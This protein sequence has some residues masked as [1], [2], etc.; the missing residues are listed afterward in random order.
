MTNSADYLCA[1]ISELLYEH[2]QL[3][4][5]G[6]GAFLLQ[7][8]PAV[9]D[10]LQG[11]LL[12][13]SLDVSFNTNL[14]MDDGLL[15]E[16]LRLRSGWS[17][18]AASDAINGFVA[19]IQAQLSRGELVYLP[20]IGRLHINHENRIVFKA[21]NYNYNKD[22]FGLP[23][24]QA[25]TVSRP[26]A[27]SPAAAAAAAAAVGTTRPSAPARS[28]GLRLWY[29][30]FGVFAVLTA[31][32]IAASVYA[33]RLAAER[34]AMEAAAES[35]LAEAPAPS[36]A[37]I[38]VPPSTDL[39]VAPEEVAD[40]SPVQS[41][42]P[43]SK[44]EAPKAEA[45]KAEAPKATAPKATAPKATTPKATTPKATTPKATA[46][47]ATAP[48]ATAPAAESVP[49]KPAA[50]AAR[51]SV[52]WIAVGK[53][54]NPDNAA[55]MNKR[56]AEAGYEPFSSREGE[57]L[58]VGILLPFNSEAELQQQLAKIKQLLAPGAFVVKR[59]SLGS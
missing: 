15:L 17:A 9:V 40:P 33:N 29:W 24:V 23:V 46:P 55:R 48:K 22:S 26:A 2:R 16:H 41:E 18:E 30:V 14:V 27:S 19:D 13:P 39:P 25:T 57:L 4:L 44:A 31:G 53:F 1:L 58:R 36:G 3:H 50:P 43:A 37:R 8:K 10:N 5:P 56:I 51:T 54:G 28:G 32:M 11:Q 45:P 20:N 35:D 42:A 59:E 21:D 47:K 52:A 49:A 7:Y 38:N 34:Q 6:L 12:P